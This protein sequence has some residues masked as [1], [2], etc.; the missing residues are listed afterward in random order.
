MA[1]SRREFLC[2]CG[3]TL[4]GVALAFDRFGVINALAQSAEYKALVCIFLNGGNDS[5]NI[6]IPYDNYAEYAAVR[7]SN[8]SLNIPQDSLRIISPP[9]AGAQYGLHPALGDAASGTGLHTLWAAGKLAAVVNVGPLVQPLT[10]AEYLARPDLRPRS[11][12]SHSDQQSQWQ[13]SLSDQGS[14]TGW[15]GRTADLTARFNPADVRFPMMVTVSGVTIFTTG[16]TQRSLALA[17]GSPFRFEGFSTNPPEND[18]RFQAMRQLLAADKLASA[19]LLRSAAITMDQA[20]ENAR[21]LVNIDTINVGPFPNTSLGN[22]LLR[23]A[24]LIKLNRQA[25]SLLLNRQLF[26]CQLGGFDL[27]NNQ[28]NGMDATLGNHTNLWTQVSNGMKA[29]YDFTEREGIQNNVV[30]F[31][32]SDFARTFK[33]NSNVGTDH[34]WGSHQFVMGG[35]VRGG[36][37]YGQFQP[38]VLGDVQDS[39]SGATA[40]GRWIPTTAVDQYGATLATWY[41]VDSVDLPAVFPNLSRFSTPNLGF[42]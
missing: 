40:R 24:R 10:R 35:A 37:F 2:N 23:V 41:G 13:T 17:P 21:E 16:D 26:F 12:F 28:A 18:P 22:Q 6:I 31:T 14:A 39:D 27:H 32:L 8:A 7:S 34:A 4:G 36:D 1:Q 29:F 33:P 20:V 15:G 11:L 19:T 5:N 30:T 3:L 38:L 42:V 9:S 25:P